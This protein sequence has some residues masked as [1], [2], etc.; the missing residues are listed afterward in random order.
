MSHRGLYSQAQ[1]EKGKG[2]TLSLVFK[3]QK[4]GCIQEIPG[5]KDLK[6]MK[7]IFMQ[8]TVKQSFSSPQDVSEDSRGLKKAVEKSRRNGSMGGY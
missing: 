3:T 6:H 7:A 2:I 1:D 8:H 5:Q 4:S